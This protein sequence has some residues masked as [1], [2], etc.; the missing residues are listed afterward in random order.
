[1][2][3]QNPAFVLLLALLQSLVDTLPRDISFQAGGKTDVCHSCWDVNF[4]PKAKSTALAEALASRQ[5]VVPTLLFW[6]DDFMKDHDVHG[7][8]AHTLDGGCL[9]SRFNDGGGNYLFN[10][11]W[12]MTLSVACWLRSVCR[13]G[14]PPRVRIVCL[15]NAGKHRS[16]FLCRMLY[17]LYQIV[18]DLLG[19]K[20]R[21]IQYTWVAAARVA[22]ELRDA[23]AKHDIKDAKNANRQS[24]IVIRTTKAA[25][26]SGRVPEHLESVQLL[27]HHFAFAKQQYYHDF[28]DYALDTCKYFKA[29][30]EKPSFPLRSRWFADWLTQGGQAALEAAAVIRV[31]EHWTPI[32]LM[33][34]HVFPSQCSLCSVFALLEPWDKVAT[35]IREEINATQGAPFLAASGSAAPKPKLGMPRRSAWADEPVESQPAPAKKKKKVSFQAEEV[36]S[37]SGVSQERAQYLVLACNVALGILFKPL[38]LELLV[39]DSDEFWLVEIMSTVHRRSFR[40]RE[41]TDDPAGLLPFAQTLLAGNKALQTEMGVLQQTL[42]ATEGVPDVEFSDMS[43]LSQFEFV[44]WLHMW[45]ILTQTYVFLLSS[46]FFRLVARPL[47][48]QHN[49]DIMS[50]VHKYCYVQWLHRTHSPEVWQE[51]PL[52]FLLPNTPE[53]LEWWKQNQLQ[54]Q[55]IVE[56]SFSE[57]YALMLSNPLDDDSG[58]ERQEE[59]KTLRRRVKNSDLGL[60]PEV[61]QQFA[62]IE[63]DVYV[64]AL[65]CLPTPRALPPIRSS[66]GSLAMNWGDNTGE[67]K[68]V[69][70]EGLISETDCCIDVPLPVPHGMTLHNII[71]TRNWKESF[72]GS[73]L[74]VP[75]WLRNAGGFSA[76]ATA[77]TGGFSPPLPAIATQIHLQALGAEILATLRPDSV[78]HPHLRAHVEFTL[79]MLAS[80][81]LAR[82]EASSVYLLDFLEGAGILA[83]SIPLGRPSWIADN[84]KKRHEV[85]GSVIRPANH[86]LWGEKCRPIGTRG[87]DDEWYYYLVHDVCPLGGCKKNREAVGF[88][89][90]CSYWHGFNKKHGNAATLQAQRL[91]AYKDIGEKGKDASK[92]RTSQYF[93]DLLASLGFVAPADT[94]AAGGDDR[95]LLVGLPRWLPEFRSNEQQN[96]PGL[97]AFNSVHHL[98]HFDKQERDECLQLKTLAL[99]LHD[100]LRVLTGK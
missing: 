19:I 50:A 18:F 80:V 82:D 31:A 55:D 95:I 96:K 52:R 20:A 51:E 84:Y 60:P 64:D 34:H 32:V 27:D 23:K 26:L 62:F 14:R 72:E 66:A 61:P 7:C 1:M 33:I 77:S 11:L 81:H 25:F 8:W 39:H 75:W 100:E 43:A 91:L 45:S 58:K 16:V 37:G 57:E 30:Q 65:D 78:M 71:G 13:N 54:A 92:E 90:L 67:P 36:A 3:V 59:L 63:H 29:A 12:A 98:K 5:D 70:R 85:P 76:P 53:W 21:N 9:W 86:T 46:T 94:H 99:E 74:G 73:S 69:T 42:C 4:D 41:S 17:F 48:E 93:R 83:E 28:G 68:N 49:F 56:I 35:R 97:V 47:Q 6:L 44:V 10:A 40:M 2:V 79:G 24:G 88:G 87:Q 89:T 38:S 15:C 22:E